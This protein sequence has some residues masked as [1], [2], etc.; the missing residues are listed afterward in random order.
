MTTRSMS[1]SRNRKVAFL[2][3]S[4]VF[5]VLLFGLMRTR[6]ALPQSADDESCLQCHAYA[7]VFEGMENADSYVVEPELFSASVHGEA[8]FSCGDCHP[9]VT[10]FPH[11]DE[12]AP[13]DCGMC[14]SLEA[15]QHDRSLHGQV[16]A[17]GDP[18]APAC[19]DCHGVHDIL[20]ASDE[21][22]PTHV[23]GIP[24]LCGECHHEGSPV[25]RTHDI[26]QDHILENYSLSIHGEGL[27]EQ[28]LSVTAV[29]TSCHTSHQ[30]LPHTDPDSSIHRDRIAGTCMNCHAQI[31]HVHRQ[32]IDG[33]LWE[34]EPDHVPAC[35][36]C[37]SPHEIRRVYYET[38]AANEDCLTCHRDAELTG[39]SLG[40]PTSLF[41][42]EQ[43]FYASAHGTVACA[44]CHTEVS[45]AVRP[46]C[47]TIESPVQCEICHE[48]EV[49]QYEISIHGTLAAEGDTDAPSCMDCHERHTTQT[50]HLPTSPTFPRNVPDL[51][52][53]C[54]ARGEPAS[55]R[56]DE[57]QPVEHYEIS[58]HGS[59][60]FDSGLTVTATCSSCHSA[61][62]TLPADDPRSTV[63]HENIVDTCGTCHIGI[64]EQLKTSIHWS[65]DPDT[66]EDLPTC[67]DCHT[68]HDISR[69]DRADFRLLMMDQC[70]RCH[71]EEAETFFDTFHGKVSRLGDEAAAKCY[72][73]HGTHNIL[74]ID[75]PD[76]TLGRNHVVETCGQCHSGA[77]I[78]FTGY[79]THATH[80]DPDKYPLLFLTFWAM[81]FLLIGVMSFALIHTAVW[82]FRLARTPELRKKHHKP[83]PGEKLY[84]RF[85]KEQ[86]M[87]HLFML[88]SFFILA[89]TG[90]I[91]KFSYMGWA[92]WAAGVVGGF[93]TT[94]V[95][96]RIG[97]IVLM[98]VFV[99][100]L[101]SIYRA[102]RQSGNSWRK[103]VFSERSLML[104]KRDLKELI[105]SFKWFLGRGPRPKYGRF[106]YWERFDYFA[107][108]W[109]MFIIGTTGL[110]LWFPEFFTL[111][112]P[113]WT[114]NIATILHS[115][116]ALLAVAFIFTV[117]FFNTHFR[118]DQFP[119][120]LVI[121]T[122]QVP[123][124]E[125]KRDKPREYEQL[126]E[127]GTLEEHLV[128]A[129]TKKFTRAARIFGFSALGI[130]LVLIGLIVYSMLTSMFGAAG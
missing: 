15:A 25:S 11:L 107:V 102:K 119:I 109:G 122:G 8:G 91:L 112:L 127:S 61:H 52:A 95:L 5:V 111:V 62:M 54:H 53:E 36:D 30:I 104:G 33:E 37:H 125:L 60:L 74:P 96:H 121:F 93:Q 88:L 114:V 31:E 65:Q 57:V 77:N 124:E 1:T 18:L 80:H 84:R 116:E 85:T 110:M 2:G 120:D 90:M 76:S 13:V 108:F 34:S 106:T 67:Y 113:G 20:R 4:V 46:S 43:A 6:P 58:I 98:G 89:L 59:G 21:R 16:L 26:G 27:F 51:C 128:P 68:A 105:Q 14:H 38:G 7:A 72:D 48:S 75:D 24:V 71:E 35:V 10:P 87:L 56:N 9:G 22:S 123:L 79:L 42:D 32:V 126:V 50:Q 73:C 97:A 44:Q 101:R 64:S 17:E 23:M 28:G 82:L 45:S 12:A 99:Y 3:G 92:Q 41:F 69:V 129:A 86:R 29:C 19:A 81:T 117:H 103:F 118:P 40:E 49:E 55:R 78:R 39:T 100:H 66:E 115:D 130:G 47:T 70:G 63:H 83:K 94:G